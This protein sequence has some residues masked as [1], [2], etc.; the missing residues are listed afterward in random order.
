[1]QFWTSILT[2]LGFYKKKINIL[3][4][5]LDNSGKTTI[6]NNNLG[7]NSIPANEIVPTVGFSVSTFNRDVFK[8]TVFE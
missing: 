4:V 5:G 3:C 6:L 8:F 2:T 7:P 1:M